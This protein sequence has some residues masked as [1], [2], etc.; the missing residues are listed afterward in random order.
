VLGQGRLGTVNAYYLMYHIERLADWGHAAD[1]Q[2]ILDQVSNVLG[3]FDLNLT[4]AALA[5]ARG[6]GTGTVAAFRAALK[7]PLN[8]Q[9]VERIAG[10]LVA[11]PDAGLYRDL[12]ARLA[13]EPALESAV[14]GSGL[15]ITAIVCGL[16]AESE[17]WKNA[18]RHLF[19]SRYPAVKAINFRKR[20]FLAPDT[21]THLVNT[22]SMPREIILSLFEQVAPQVDRP[23][24]PIVR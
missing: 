13:R 11:H 3:N 9:R 21:V 18:G 14:D 19:A 7:L 17:H 20:D 12:A 23:V 24:A 6:D 8:P 5:K 1:A 10:Y 22:V 15:W 16:P 2:I 4:Q